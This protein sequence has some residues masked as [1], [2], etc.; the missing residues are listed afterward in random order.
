[1]TNQERAKRL[2]DR[3]KQEVIRGAGK[4]LKAALVFLYARTKEALNVR[5]P[6]RLVHGIRGDYWKAT[7]SATPGAPMRKVSGNAQRSLFYNMNSD[8]QSGVI[9]MTAVSPKGF[10]YPK[11]HEVQDPSSPSSPSSGQHP[12]IVP[13]ATKYQR[14]IAKIVGGQISLESV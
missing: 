4:G 13:T 7:T 5:A 3:I 11:H 14:E 1:M 2:A 12:S 8:G 10:S 6:R 9:G